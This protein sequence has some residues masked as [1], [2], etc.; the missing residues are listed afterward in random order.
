MTKRREAYSTEQSLK[1][2]DAV[3]G[4]AVGQ[5]LATGSPGDLWRTCATCRHMKLKGPALCNKYNL[6]PPVL[7]IIGQVDCKDYDDAEDIPF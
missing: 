7:V 3:L 5:W 6:V 4:K 2:F 1:A